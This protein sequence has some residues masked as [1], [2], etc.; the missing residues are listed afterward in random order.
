MHKFAQALSDILLIET[1]KENFSFHH[2]F[3]L[4]LYNMLRKSGWR[5]IRRNVDR[6]DILIII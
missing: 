6:D 5:Q 3:C 4:I 2:K 1:T